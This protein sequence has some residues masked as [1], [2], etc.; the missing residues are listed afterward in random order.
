MD[1]RALG[2]VLFV[3]DCFRLQAEENEEAGILG[4]T[5]PLRIAAGGRV[6]PV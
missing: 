5:I 3:L 6:L 4:P 1:Q 2:A